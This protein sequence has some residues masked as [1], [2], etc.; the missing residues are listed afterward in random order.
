MIM[1]IYAIPLLSYVAFGGDFSGES[2]YGEREGQIFISNHFGW[3]AALFLIAHFHVFH[4]KKEKS[5][6]Q[7]L[8]TIFLL[9]LAVYLLIVSEIDLMACGVAESYSCIILL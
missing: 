2:I 5:V 7:R 6:I 1:I 4:K 9:L 3:S 8:V